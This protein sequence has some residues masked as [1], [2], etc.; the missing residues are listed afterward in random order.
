MTRRSTLEVEL[1]DTSMY[2]RAQP[3]RR[4]TLPPRSP[5]GRAIDAGR[6]RPIAVAVT[7][8]ERR[9]D[10]ILPHPQYGAQGWVAVV[11]P[12][13]RDEVAQMASLAHHR[14]AARERD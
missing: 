12:A 10:T 5:L 2:V 1:D 7:V 6:V 13:D 4:L 3:G 11:N 14:A 9:S 8:R